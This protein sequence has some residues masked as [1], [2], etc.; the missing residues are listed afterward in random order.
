MSPIHVKGSSFDIQESLMPHP[1]K[2]Q[3]QFHVGDRCPNCHKADLE[4]GVKENN[5]VLLYCP[6]CGFIA[7]RRNQ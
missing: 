6:K 4:R 1:L 2:E 7:P 3:Y 5:E